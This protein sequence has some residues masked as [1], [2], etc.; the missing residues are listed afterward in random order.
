M[1]NSFNQTFQTSVMASGHVTRSGD[2]W[3]ACHAMLAWC[4]PHVIL[5]LGWL[6]C[7]CLTL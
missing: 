2:L 5:L 4:I 6:F 7:L 1:Q 3:L